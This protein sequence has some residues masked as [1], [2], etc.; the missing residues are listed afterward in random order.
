MAKY[1]TIDGGTTNTRISLADNYEIVARKKYPVGARANM[2]DKTLLE[3]TLR[4]GIKEILKVTG[5]EKDE[6][7]CV[8][9]SGMIT[10]EFGTKEL[11][12][13][14]TPAGK[15]QLHDSM[16]RDLNPNITDIPLYYIRGVKTEGGNPLDADMMRGEESEL[17]G[18]LGEE[19]GECV[20]VLA[21][22][23][24]KV[25]WVEDG[26]IKRFDTMLTGEMLETLSEN[27]ILSDAVKLENTQTDWEYLW[28]GY[29]FCKNNG[30]NTALFKVRTLKN[31]LKKN[32]S[33]I[34]S[35]F[36]GAVLQGEIAQITAKTPGCVVIGGKKQIK[37][38]MAYILKKE[39]KGSVTEIDDKAA[40]SA[41]SIGMIR[42]YEC[43]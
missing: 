2:H 17:F 28:L 26:Q 39:L 20:Y 38:A 25:I 3:R 7:E 23:H 19:R 4:E 34:Y 11:E 24:S 10:S 33:Q 27:T 40:E 32:D 8:L 42:I 35:F 30:I 18:L 21:G 15:K 13:I 22:T 31:L 6:I 29:V 43:N 5:A 36:M 37:S 1:I 14:C 12:H 9:A 41:N 16:V